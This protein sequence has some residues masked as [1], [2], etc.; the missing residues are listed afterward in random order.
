MY[1]LFNICAKYLSKECHSYWRFLVALRNPKE[2]FR[3]EHDRAVTSRRV[4]PRPPRPSI[5]A[6][7]RRRWISA[8]R[9]PITYSSVFK[10]DSR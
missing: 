6:A 1:A 7:R 5:I 2:D 3:K 4:A 8:R 9:V 10:I